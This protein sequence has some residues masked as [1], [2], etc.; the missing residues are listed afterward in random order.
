MPEPQLT[1]ML[2]IRTANQTS[3][4][5]A[6]STDKENHST[7]K[8]E[9]LAKEIHDGILSG[10]ITGKLPGVR[11]LSRAHGLNHKTVKKSL[12]LLQ[13]QGIVYSVRGRG[14]YVSSSRDSQNI[15]ITLLMM[16][17]GDVYGAM[18]TRIFTG[19]AKMKI[20]PRV[21]DILSYEYRQH[22]IA[23]LSEAAVDKPD[24]LIVQAHCSDIHYPTFRK[25]R[26]SFK[27][28]L[29][30]EAFEFGGLPKDSEYILA[31]YYRGAFLAAE[32]LIA[33]GCRKILFLRADPKN[34]QY[35]KFVTHADAEKGFMTA[36]KESGKKIH[37]SVVMPDFH[38]IHSAL[39]TIKNAFVTH[40]PD[41][42]VA[43]ADY[44]LYLMYP[45]ISSLKLRIPQDI[46]TVG[47]Y[48]TPWSTAACPEFSSISIN[49][50]HIAD[51]VVE[52][53]NN[54]AAPSL[55]CRMYAEPAL[56]V[57]A[58]SGSHGLKI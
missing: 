50:T 13:E 36:A 3:S 12:D 44:W 20:K 8:Y 55:P 53:V 54:N 45:V 48:D 16:T 9:T 28:V 30:I 37:T 56:I 15:K 11:E 58:S 43:M 40:R 17:S 1:K 27:R 41:A 52:L 21:I 6:Y 39:G 49:E 46:K 25:L 32:H 35:G 18:Y 47:F 24:I 22:M 4:P 31:D 38:D 23:R 26:A 51:K 34:P 2:S 57:R 10:K 7:T 29:F 5:S 42:V 14:M 19:L 33:Q